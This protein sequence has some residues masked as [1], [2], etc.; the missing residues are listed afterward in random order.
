MLRWVGLR[1]EDHPNSEE[2]KQASGMEFTTWEPVLHFQV[3][4]HQVRVLFLQVR[5]DDNTRR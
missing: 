2:L 4:A 1:V 5:A 3:S